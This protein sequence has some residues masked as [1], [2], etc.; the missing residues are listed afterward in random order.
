MTLTAQ[1]AYG[2]EATCSFQLTVD[3]ILDTETFTN[4]SISLH[5]NPTSGVVTL[6]NP[7]NFNLNVI[8]VYSVSGRLIKNIG[9]EGMGTSKVLSMS[10]LAKG[11][12]FFLV[13]GEEGQVTKKIVKN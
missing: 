7:S 2:N 9:L 10:N 1:D 13:K 5:P 11:T 4:K 6:S 8:E 12:Y 3:A